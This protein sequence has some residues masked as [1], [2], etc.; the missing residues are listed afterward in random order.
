MKYL[1]FF[2]L[3]LTFVGADCETPHGL[4]RYCGGSKVETAYY[5]VSGSCG[6]NGTMMVT[7]GSA[8]SCAIGVV[9]PTAVALPS[10]GSFNASA[11]ATLFELSKGNWNLDD[12]SIGIMNV[13]TFLDC[14]GSAANAAGDIELTCEENVCAVG[15]SDDVECNTG[16]TCVAHLTPTTADAG[17]RVPPLD[18][19]TRDTSSGDGSTVDAGTDGSAVDA[20]SDTSTGGANSEAGHPLD[21]GDAGSG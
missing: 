17:S 5:K 1:L 8:N 14:A 21:A 7:V 13:G 2:L 3:A 4:T 12:P 15:D 10:V 11:G 9:E 19:S 6:A 20:R 16:G 18:A